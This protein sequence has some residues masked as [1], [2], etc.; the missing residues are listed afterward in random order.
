MARIEARH[1]LLLLRACTYTRSTSDFYCR[2]VAHSTAFLNERTSRVNV[3]TC[4]RS[5]GIRHTLFTRNSL[6]GCIYIRIVS[7]NLYLQYCKHSLHQISLFQRS[8]DIAI[9]M[10]Y[11]LLPFKSRKIVLPDRAAPCNWRILRGNDENY[12]TH[13]VK[14]RAY[15]HQLKRDRRSART[16]DRG[17]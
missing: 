16:R 10:R 8:F 3:L 12:R 5:I 7:L 13:P 6:I 11:L 17:G 4:G 15:P 14:S 9:L 2:L 1:H